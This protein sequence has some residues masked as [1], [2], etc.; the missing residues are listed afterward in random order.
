VRRGFTLVELLVVIAIIGLLAAILLPA[1]SRAR[2]AARR[3]ACMNN[4][5]QF[6]LAFGMY[7]DENGGYLPPLAPY[8]SVRNDALS[9]PLWSAPAGAAV[10][11][12]YLTD[13]AVARCPSDPGADPGW[14]HVAQRLPDHGHFDRWV[15]DAAEAGDAVGHDY[16][17]S[18]MLGRSYI[19]KGY[20][21]TRTQEYMGVWAA[22]AM[23]PV[24]A[25]VPIHGVGEV[26]L[27][28]YVDDLPLHGPAWPPWVP[29]PPQA[30]GTAGGDKVLRLRHGVE[31]FFITDINRP[32]VTMASA[33]AVPV[34]W[35]AIGS[36]EFDDNTAGTLV[37]NHAPG[38]A[39][40]LM[41][42]GSARFET[43]PGAFPV[44]NDPQCLKEM[45]HF[46]LY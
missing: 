44:T 30:E 14:K 37:F 32:G 41:L 18:A 1:L 17:L 33:S 19:Y 11:P 46:G 36:S 5:R 16:F 21:A 24:H 26:R 43:Y 15:R 4:L 3:A 22:T 40:V 20:V 23:N 38:G 27:K 42:D 8:G 6:G 12:E 39:N 31:R 2:E 25:T 10:Y 7:A 34:L 45:S 9:S 35:D 28:S 29:G 13:L